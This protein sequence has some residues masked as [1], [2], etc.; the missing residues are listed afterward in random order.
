MNA[1]SNPSLHELL[2]F[3]WNDYSAITPAAPRIKT[4]LAELGERQVNDHIAFRT[5][6]LD[7]INVES[8]G[9]TF[10]R[11][12]YRIS[13]EYSF[14]KKKLRAL[15]YAPPEPGLPHVFISELLLEGFS[16][17]LRDIVQILVDQVPHERVGSTD[18]FTE[19]PT[20]KPVAYSDYLRL[21]QESE[22]AAWLSAF[23]IR[24]NH[25]TVLINELTKFASL[26]EFNDWLKEQGFTMNDSG[27]EVKGSPEELLEQSSI[28]AQR[29]EWE[30]AAGEKAT[31]PSCYHEFAR[32]YPDPATGNLYTGF[33]ARS[34]DRIFESTD[35]SRIA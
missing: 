28:L 31:I 4:L 34:A 22:Y 17:E 12:G 11:R 21:Q 8:L 32:R 14:E 19:L 2:E 13:G 24:V 26:Q 23:G 35:S 15:S 10:L 3:F 18:L 25:F 7:P 5:F 16:E 30:F 6:N 9:E 29:I 20:W 27:G 1:I 33:I